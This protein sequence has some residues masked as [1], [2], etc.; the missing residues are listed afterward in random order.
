MDPGH[1]RT[2]RLAGGPPRGTPG[3]HAP[4]PRPRRLLVPH[5]PLRRLPIWVSRRA[6][7]PLARAR[8][9]PETG[10][11][12]P[13]STWRAQDAQSLVER[14]RNPSLQRSAL[15]SSR[16]RFHARP[17]GPGRI[18]IRRDACLPRVAFAEPS[19]TFRNSELQRSAAVIA[20][21]FSRPAME[22]RA[23]S[24]AQGESRRSRQSGGLSR[25]IQRTHMDV[26][27]RTPPAAGM[28]ACLV[29]GRVVSRIRPD[30]CR[31]DFSRDCRIEPRSGFFSFPRSA[32]ETASYN[33]K[34]ARVSP[35]LSAPGSPRRPCR[36]RCRSR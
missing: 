33:S 26:R 32:T 22:D 15:T 23:G 8:R 25:R 27:A 7:A 18:A 28:P 14:L 20:R 21:S 13:D 9:T 24:K 30:F 2:R 5:R 6:R 29:R 10:C 3:P 19:R 31:S 36:R 17:G 35:N 34:Y 12:G 1:D 16:A 4:P 11:F